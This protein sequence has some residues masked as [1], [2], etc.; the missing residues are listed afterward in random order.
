MFS[1]LRFGGSWGP[2]WGLKGAKIKSFGNSGCPLEPVLAPKEPPRGGPNPPKRAQEAPESTLKSIFKSKISIYQKCGFSV[3]KCSFLRVG[4]PAWELKIDAERLQEIEKTRRK[5]RAKK[6]EKKVQTYGPNSIWKSIWI[7]DADPCISTGRKLPLFTIIR[8]LRY[9]EGGVGRTG[10]AVWRRL[11]RF[12][13][14]CFF[15]RA[16]AFLPKSGDFL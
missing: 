3:V 9:F 4:G 12:G 6:E 15:R 10:A 2:S 16:I 7:D 5:K 11:A 14:L 8:F 13:V 1:W